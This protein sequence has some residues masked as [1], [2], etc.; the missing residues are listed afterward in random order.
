MILAHLPAGYVLSR[1]VGAARGHLLWVALF[2][3]VL[4]DFDMFW[5]HLMDAG[6]IH[7]HRYWVHI[8][9]FWLMIAA[10]A[11]PAVFYVK[12][13]LFG[14]ALIFF[15]SIFIHLILDSVGG[16]IMWLWPYDDRLISIVIVPA[17][18]SH[19]V[20]SFLLHWTFL[21]ELAILATAVGLFMTR[22]RP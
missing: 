13:A 4:P 9:G 17:T 14:A 18:Q 10:V 2:A 5:F 20:L 11:L 1:S 6:R 16:G 12:R 21:A 19:W 7:H 15:A 22:A 3:S 8:P